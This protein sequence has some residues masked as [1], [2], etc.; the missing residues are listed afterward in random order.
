M[1]NDHKAPRAPSTNSTQSDL[2]S[3]SNL[4]ITSSNMNGKMSKQLVKAN[5]SS[6]AV[7]KA[8]K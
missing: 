5:S 8:K 2:L 4:M 3:E 7:T 1:M 6:V